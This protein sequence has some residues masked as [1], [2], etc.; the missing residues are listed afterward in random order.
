M[1]QASNQKRLGLN[2]TKKR[3][4]RRKN[5]K[6]DRNQVRPEKKVGLLTLAAWLTELAV[7]VEP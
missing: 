4:L 6:N 3:L 5:D 7:T 1:N 2:K